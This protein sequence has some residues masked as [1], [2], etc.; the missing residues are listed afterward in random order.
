MDIIDFRYRPPYGS[1]RE[2]IMYRD[3][4]RAK[5]CSEA[6][7]MNQ[8]PA[9][10]ARDMEASLTEMDRAGIGMAVLAGR[11][12]LPHIGVVDNQDIVDLIHAY[13]GRFTGMAGVDPSDG[14]EAMEELER[15]VVGEGLRGIVMEPGLTKTPMF[16]EDERIFPLYG[17]CQALGVPVML[18]VGSNC[19]PDIEYSKPEHAERVAKAFPKLNIIQMAQSISVT[20]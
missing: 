7:G 12:V 6:F 19:G 16:V 5:R 18:M 17:R 14:P 15:Y 20:P 8:S 13:P 2:T 3:L 10:A 11:K 4:E 9:V 1:Y